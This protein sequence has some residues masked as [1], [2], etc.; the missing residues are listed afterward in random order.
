MYR[1]REQFREQ[2]IPE[3]TV[4][5]WEL[6]LSEIWGPRT[7]YSQNLWQQFFPSDLSYLLIPSLLLPPLFYPL[8]FQVFPLSLSS[9]SSCF[10]SLYFLG[11][12]PIFPFALFP[13]FN[14][15]FS[16]PLL[17]PNEETHLRKEREV[18]GSSNFTHDVLFVDLLFF[19]SLLLIKQIFFVIHSISLGFQLYL[20]VLFLMIRLEVNVCMHNFSLP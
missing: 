18:R 14:F 17:K 20:F 4:E 16:F 7:N 8:D 12:S 2:F 19:S 1:K 6:C 9:L 11:L 5:N 10:P 3:R 15:C 13:F